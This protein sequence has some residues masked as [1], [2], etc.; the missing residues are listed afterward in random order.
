[1]KL[2]RILFTYCFL[3]V[4][5]GNASADN[6][7]IQ[8]VI[9]DAKNQNP[10]GYV[11]IGLLNT[12]K[13][14]VSDMDGRFIL[15]LNE[16]DTN[17]KIKISHLGYA[18][19]LLLLKDL[20]QDEPLEIFLEPQSFSLEPIEIQASKLFSKKIGCEKIET[21]RNVSFSLSKQPNQNLGAAIGK[22]IKIK[23]KFYLD[24]VAFYIR[25][26]SFDTVRFRVNIHKIKDGRPGD[27]LNTEAIIVELTNQ[28]RGWIEVDLTPY[29]IKYNQSI[30]PSIEWIYHSKKGRRLQMPIAMP[31]FASTHYYRYGSQ[32]KWKRFRA[33]SSAIYVKVRTE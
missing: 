6:L 12:A 1:V 25:Q 30:I 31:R 29:E 20:K 9:K 26:N 17:Q 27:L 2:Y 23:K 14:T 10:L 19:Q 5:L 22:K 18:T 8:G 13:G 7:T 16:I 21:Q 32:N 28:K 3:L 33:M 24:T 11:N 4:V 15:F